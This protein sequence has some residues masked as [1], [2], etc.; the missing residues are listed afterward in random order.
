MLHSADRLKV[1]LAMAPVFQILISLLELP[2]QTGG[3]GTTDNSSVL[4]VLHVHSTSSKYVTP[5]LSNITSALGVQENTLWH[6]LTRGS[7]VI[8]MAVDNAD[9]TVNSDSIP[10]TTHTAVSTM[11][12]GNFAGGRVP[13]RTTDNI[14][15]GSN[16]ASENVHGH[17]DNLMNTGNVSKESVDGHKDNTMDIGNVTSEIVPGRTTDN[18]FTGNLADNS[19][20]TGDVA[21]T[22]GGAVS[23]DIVA[24]DSVP[25]QTADSHTVRSTTT[26]AVN[27]GRDQTVSAAS[28]NI[29]TVST[30]V[31]I[32]R[33]NDHLTTEIVFTTMTT[34]PT[35]V[36]TLITTSPVTPR[37]YCQAMLCEKDAG[38]FVINTCHKH[39]ADD[40]HVNTYDS[41]NSGERKLCQSQ[42]PLLLVHQS[43]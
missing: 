30:S 40:R 25:R 7:D 10:T 12:T 17:T 24:S 2:R 28:G 39:L 11:D 42:H 5:K 1:F 34:V 3:V 8:S 21:G 35:S 15:D 4:P 23:A 33:E 18:M 6:V 31:H 13:E 32:R 27:S 16:A 14:I 38:Y 43:S 26:R 20:N 19:K 36:F 41:G 9:R 37:Q 22:T 29:G